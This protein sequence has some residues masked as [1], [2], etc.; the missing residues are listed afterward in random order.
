MRKNRAVQSSALAIMVGTSIAVGAPAA[1][2]ATAENTGT[3]TSANAIVRDP[4]SS[5][6]LC[7]YL[8]FNGWSYWNNDPGEVQGD[9]NNLLQYHKF[10]YAESLWNNGNS[11]NVLVRDSNN[12]YST[13]LSLG[14]KMNLGNNPLYHDVASNNWCV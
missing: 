7:A 9:N 14:E 4:C 6:S 12:G 11:C 5:G 1:S 8:R 10:N 2:A 13:V 3:A